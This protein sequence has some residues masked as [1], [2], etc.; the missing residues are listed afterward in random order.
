MSQKVSR[1]QIWLPRWYFTRWS[2]VVT[3]HSVNSGYVLLFEL[4][5]RGSCLGVFHS[6]CDR[7]ASQLGLG[8]STQPKKGESGHLDD[9]I[10]TCGVC[11]I[12]TVE[13]QF[14]HQTLSSPEW[15]L[16]SN[17]IVRLE[18][19]IIFN[20]LISVF[21]VFCTV[22]LFCFLFW[23]KSSFQLDSE[24]KLWRKGWVCM[25]K[26]TILAG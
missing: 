10:I 5:I 25:W 4:K 8:K 11:S 14:P 6:D 24:G 9:C 19:T 1:A 3:G 22:F 23:S 2:N 13:A 17:L 12:F 26:A 16:S 20:K 18:R 21:Q 7:V 15:Y